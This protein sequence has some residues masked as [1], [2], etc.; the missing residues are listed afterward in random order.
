VGEAGGS[1]PDSGPGDGSDLIG[2]GDDADGER[3]NLTCSDGI[4][5]DNDGKID[6]DDLG[7]KLDTQV[8][9]CQPSSDFRFS[10][11]ARV[12][13]IGYEYQPSNDDPGEFTTEFDSLQLRMLGQMPFI[14]N[15]FFLISARAEKTPRLVFALFQVPLGK[16]GHYFNVNSGGGGLALEPIRSVHK[17]LLADPAFYVYNAFEQGNGAALEFGGP[18]DKKNKFL[19]RAFAAGGSGR[20]AGNIGGTFF[21][22]NTRNYTWGVGTQIWMNFVGYYSRW[23]TPFLYTKAPLAVAL[24]LGAKFDQRAQERYPAWNSQF[25]F[26][27]WRFHVQFEYYGKRELAF[28]NFQN[29]YNGQ[30]GFLAWQKRLLLAFDYGQYLATDFEQPPVEPGAD[31]R[32]QL[33]ETQ[34][35]FAAHV[36][37][38]RD[39]FFAS[40]IW[41]NRNIEPAEYRGEA[42]IQEINDVRLLFTYRW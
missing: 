17:R 39:V 40:A 7:C 42:G 12:K 13:A 6:C 31:L 30:L 23:D 25:I 20:F 34:Y 16:R 28:R 3:D 15:S 1:G 38:W 10:V 26:R 18:F 4:D 14:Q 41:R 27:W 5:N 2:K 24:A 21:P 11:V 36:F 37:L 9:V 22:D 32:R 33:G 8:T 29:A 35:R 19:F